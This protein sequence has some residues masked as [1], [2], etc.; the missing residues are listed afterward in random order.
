[1]LNSCS[2]LQQIEATPLSSFIIHL[3]QPYFGASLLHCSSYPVQFIFFFS[4]LFFFV[5]SLFCE[6]NLNFRVRNQMKVFTWSVAI[7]Q[8]E[9]GQD[10][11]KWEWCMRKQSTAHDSCIKIIVKMW[12]LWRVGLSCLVK[13]SFI[14]WIMVI[15][16]I[17]S[18]LC[19]ER[20][21]VKCVHIVQFFSNFLSECWKMT[22][23]EIPTC[24]IH[25]Y[26]FL[27]SFEL[28]HDE[29]ISETA[30]RTNI[31]EPRLSSYLLLT[32]ETGLDCT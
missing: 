25:T 21:R 24:I 20:Y 2:E 28:H 26:K 4:I 23:G 13:F 17:K 9:Y 14:Y 5:I 31:H 16:L 19:V 6:E 30:S 15:S 27:L 18:C 32:P 12:E 22:K 1:M 11:W 29:D 7:L 8:F 10:R 3:Q